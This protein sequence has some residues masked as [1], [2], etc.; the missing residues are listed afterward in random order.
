MVVRRQKENADAQG[1][2]LQPKASASTLPQV[3]QVCLVRFAK[4]LR[5]TLL[6]RSAWSLARTMYVCSHTLTLDLASRATHPNK[7]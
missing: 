1:K 5:S 4:L 7:R 2:L 6:M 3:K